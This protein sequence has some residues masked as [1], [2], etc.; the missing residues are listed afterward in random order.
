ME[1]LCE[2]MV[3]RRIKD[4]ARL[5]EVPPPRGAFL[6]L[7]GPMRGL[8]ACNFPAFEAAA[9]RLQA[10]G[11]RVLNP[12]EFEAEGASLRPIHSYM[13]RDLALVAVAD[14]VVVLPGWTGSEGSWLEVRQAL[15]LRIPVVRLDDLEAEVR[16]L[17]PRPAPEFPGP[18]SDHPDWVSTAEL[19]WL[20]EAVIWPK[21]LATRGAGQSEYAH[22]ESNALGNFDR[23]AADLG[24]SREEVLWVYLRKHLD[25]I[26]AWIRGYR[27]QREDV[28]GRILDAVV[29]LCLLWAMVEAKDPVDLRRS[30]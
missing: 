22:A 5:S 15:E 28:R 8:P 10:Q 13:R 20:M 29:Y 21:V 16:E 9:E 12:A 3:C 19:R 26:L 11:Y 2:C 27:S 1:Q 25:G 7:S 18:P 30:R 6:Y 23:I 14:A 17:P 24:L 4:P